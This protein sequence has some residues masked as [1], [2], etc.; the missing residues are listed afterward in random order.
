[1]SDD[2][3]GSGYIHTFRVGLHDTDAA[4]VLFFAQLFRHA[5]EAYEAFMAHIGF[6]LPEMIRQGDYHLPLVNAQADYLA[7]ISHGDDIQVT[8]QVAQMS[9]RSFSMAYT[10]TAGRRKTVAHAKTVHVLIA[11]PDKSVAT[12][13]VLPQALRIA[14]ARYLLQPPATD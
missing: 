3:N 6:P 12:P 13:L 1:M 8:V 11:H 9:T 14:L 5:H 2:L 4:G 7:K 10:F